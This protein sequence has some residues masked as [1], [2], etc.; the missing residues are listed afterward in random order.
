MNFLPVVQ[1]ELRVAARLPRT[2]YTRMLAA[3]AGVVIVG[4]VG[5]VQREMGFGGGRMLFFG[6]T[7]LAGWVC[8]LGGVRL[9]S[10]AISREQ[11]EGTLGF[12]F[13]SHLSGIEVVL[14]K[15]TAHATRGGYALLATMPVMAIPFLDGGVQPAEF[16]LTMLALAN[17][18]FF[19]V[20][21][22]LLASSLST[23]PRR[24]LGSATGVVFFFWLGLPML[25]QLAS[26]APPGSL[27]SRLAR[28]CVCLSPA[29][30]TGLSAAFGIATVKPWVPL[31]CTHGLG[32]G[33]LLSAAVATRRAWQERPAGRL[34]ARGGGWWRDF[35]LGRPERRAARRT[36][37]L[38]RNAFLWLLVRQR[39][40]PLFP[41][42]FVAALLGLLA[43]LWQTNAAVAGSS[44]AAFFSGFVSIAL[45]LH[46][47]LKFWIASEVAYAMTTQRRQGTLE[48]LL[49]TP[50]A[51]RDVVRAQFLAIRRQF[52]W[53]LLAVAAVTLGG[54]LLYSLNPDA[55]GGAAAVGA[56]VGATLAL[57]A[58]T[59]TVVYL[60]TW[61]GIAS[62]KPQHAAGN[63]AFRALVLPWLILLFVTP[64]VIRSGEP[65]ESFFILW[66]LVGF[67]FDLLWW[68]H[69]RRQ[70][71]TRFRAEVARAAGHFPR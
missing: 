62:R 37:A 18:L 27:A 1:R 36:A 19:S 41:F 39:W 16:W 52:G 56:A 43:L 30:A 59:L 49:T 70:L 5:L 53:P 11:R 45:I 61:L 13:L 42:L 17:T 40:K 14:G 51:V 23:E 68:Q 38:D 2:H 28:V 66:A 71:A 54:A 48:L 55:E 65:F 3:L 29:S 46:V 44:H 8:L 9:T 25:A 57:G 4:Y 32:W 12:L 60:G 6:L 64:T 35:V 67:G 63:T 47:V 15:L 24:A 34:R 31:L 58:D 21:V 69:A 33:F 7:Q 20:C 10:D 26:T 50:L 22:G